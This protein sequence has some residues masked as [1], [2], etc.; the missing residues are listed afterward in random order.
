MSN[1]S[2][3]SAGSPGE[4]TVETPQPADTCPIDH[5]WRTFDRQKTVGMD[6]ASCEL[7]RV[8]HGLA[9]AQA[10]VR[11]HR[12][13]KRIGLRGL[14]RIRV[15]GTMRIYAPE[16]LPTSAYQTVEQ[17]RRLLLTTIQTVLGASP[18]V[19]RRLPQRLRKSLAKNKT[20]RFLACLNTFLEGKKT[21]PPL[22]SAEEWVVCLS[23]IQNQL[24]NGFELSAYPQPFEAA[25][26]IQTRNRLHWIVPATLG[27]LALASII[28]TATQ[29]SKFRDSAVKTYEVIS[30]ETPTSQIQNQLREPEPETPF[31]SI[32]TQRPN[33]ARLS[34]P[35]PAPDG[36]TPKAVTIPLPLSPSPTTSN[37]PPQKTTPTTPVNIVPPDTPSPK[38]SQPPTLQ[39]VPKVPKPDKPVTPALP[40]PIPP[41]QSNNSRPT[42][43]Q[44]ETRA[45]TARW[46]VDSRTGQAQVILDLDD[47]TSTLDLSELTRRSYNLGTRT[48][49]VGPFFIGK[50]EVTQAQLQLVLGYNPTYAPHRRT[51]QGAEFYPASGIAW[52]TATNFCKSVERALGGLLEVRLPMELEWQYVAERLPKSAKLSDY[53]WLG[54]AA[55]TGKP[56]PVREKSVDSLGLYDLIGNVAE[57]TMDFYSDTPF[58]TSSGY[59]GMP[60]PGR[61]RPDEHVVRGGSYVTPLSAMAS[62]RCPRSAVAVDRDLGFRIVV[63]PKDKK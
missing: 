26:M 58:G 35:T 63:I 24:V 47:K 43:V 51:G 33:D 50:T 8:S 49:Q 62:S 9:L 44:P 22:P 20:H 29:W 18:D 19:R 39:A 3:Q 55:S 27:I 56:H 11:A 15:D 28:V 48:F 40:P 17:D 1:T 4:P 45:L 42:P 41:A 38:G 46:D 61:G 13:G 14:T 37:M 36:G 2:P 34:S 54:E 32:V 7:N 6:I 12:S 21:S 59:V 25:R 53:A 52:N 16:W 23:Q 30:I 31:P 10:F 60:S 57:W 5:F